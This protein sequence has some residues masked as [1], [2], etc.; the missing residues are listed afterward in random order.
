MQIGVVKEIKSSENRVAVIP[1][2]VRAFIAHGHTVFVEKGSGA[3]SGFRDNEYSRTGAKL[4]N[5]QVCY[6]A[7]AEALNLPCPQIDF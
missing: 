1:A 7:V 4:L 6:P 3:G 5:G 2:G